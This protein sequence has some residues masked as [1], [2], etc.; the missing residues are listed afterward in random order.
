MNRVETTVARPDSTRGDAQPSKRAW[1]SITR[2]S[3]PVNGLEWEVLAETSENMQ[4]FPPKTPPSTPG[5]DKRAQ[6]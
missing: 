6:L 2:P 4:V 1:E 5:S 3:G